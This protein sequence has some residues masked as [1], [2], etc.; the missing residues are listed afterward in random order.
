MPP[1][2]KRPLVLVLLVL[3]MLPTACAAPPLPPTDA[4][5]SQSQ[6]RKELEHLYATLQASHYDLFAR[7]PRAEYDALYHQTWEGFDGPRHSDALR[8][9]FQRF[10]AYGNVAHARIDPP[11]A[12]WEAH[13][14]SG[15]RAFPLYLRVIDGRVFVQDDYSG[16]AD[17][18]PGDEV[19]SVAGVPAL[20]WMNR[21][22]TLVSADNDYLAYTQMETQLPVLIWWYG[23][24]AS[25]WDI[26]IAKPAGQRRTLVIPARSRSEFEATA[27][28]RPSGFELDWN[29]RT[30]RIAD[31]GIGYLRPGPFYDNRPDASD[32]WDPSAFRTFIDEAFANFI[33]AGTRAV[34][35][36]LRNNPGGDN[37]FS[38]PMIAWFADKPF[39][40]SLQFDIRVSEAAIRSNAERLLAAGN[41][42]DTTSARLAAA[43][44]EKPVGSRVHFS[45]PLVHPRNGTRYAK[46]VYLL[47]NRHSYSNTVLVAAISQDYGFATVLGEETADLASTYGA[48]EKFR[49]PATGLEVSF[50][51]ARI[52][53]PN[54]DG[55]ARGVIPDKLI[56]TSAFATGTDEVLVEALRI[57]TEE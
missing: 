26:A 51:K 22:R 43:Y 11:M 16:V 25:K 30:W 46:P 44:A 50:P 28:A 54:G 7:R 10:V 49:L 19:L 24:R 14:A 36:D 55:R 27:A 5:L 29:A 48:A 8:R 1:I 21:V 56:P 17:I 3:A 32:P 35:I 52:L 40:F 39:N 15:G 31:G 23:E 9:E 2:L 42:P 38:D 53:R 57:V 18:A 34:L 12:E 41:D 13:R 20:Q 4:P 45:I 6:A 47:I 37:S 33:D